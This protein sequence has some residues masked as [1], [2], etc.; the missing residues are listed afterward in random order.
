MW[1]TTTMVCFSPLILWVGWMISLLFC[2]ASLLWLHPSGGSVVGQGPSLV[3][4][5]VLVVNRVASLLLHVAF[6]L[7][8]VGNIDLYIQSIFPRFWRWKLKNLL[9][10]SPITHLTLPP[11]SFNQRHKGSLD[12]SGGNSSTLDGKKYRKTFGYI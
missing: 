8:L 5:I 3:W 12:S 1:F 6:L 2:Q 10:L 4:W 11:K 9:R 7:K